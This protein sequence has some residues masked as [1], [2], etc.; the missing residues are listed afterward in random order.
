MSY[1]MQHDI[2]SLGVVLLEIGL[3]TSF[4]VYDVHVDSPM[5]PSAARNSILGP[6][7]STVEIATPKVA[8][9]SKVAAGTKATLEQLAEKELPLRLGRKYTDIVLL[10]LRVLDVGSDD[11]DGDDAEG[12]GVGI[13]EKQRSFNSSESQSMM[14]EDGLVIGVRYIENVLTKIQEINF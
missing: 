3:W 12:F 6:T 1:Q 7:N 4:V 2:Y 11:E 14:D 13:E 10:C 9:K 5:P 8:G